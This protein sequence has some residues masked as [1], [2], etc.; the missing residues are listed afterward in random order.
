[1]K[2][3]RALFLFSAGLNVLALAIF[4]SIPNDARWLGFV[5]AMAAFANI[6]AFFQQKR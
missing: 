5:F 3:T 1:M 2:N 6:M 4:F